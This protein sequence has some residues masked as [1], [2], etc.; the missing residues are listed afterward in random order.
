MLGAGGDFPANGAFVGKPVGV[1]CSLVT[2][3]DGVDQLLVLLLAL[4]SLGVEDG[5]PV[6]VDALDVLGGGD[7]NAGVFR[8][9]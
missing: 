7:D 4:G 1:S 9:P 6:E 2:S 3:L 8:L 5:R